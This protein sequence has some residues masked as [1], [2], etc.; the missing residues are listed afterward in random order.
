[1]RYAL[2]LCI[3]SALANDEKLSSIEAALAASQSQYEDVK[4]RLGTANDAEL[5]TLRQELQAHQRTLA[6]KEA[7]LGTLQRDID[8]QTKAVEVAA[9]RYVLPTTLR[10]GMHAL[11]ILSPFYIAVEPR[12][13]SRSSSRRD[14]D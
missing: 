14:L 4:S 6:E 7:S 12:I 2:F 13:C 8:T 9:N 3:S 1:M 11:T 10:A 5:P